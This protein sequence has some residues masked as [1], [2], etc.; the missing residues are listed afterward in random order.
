MEELLEKVFFFG[1]LEY[2]LLSLASCFKAPGLE[3]FK[4]QQELYKKNSSNKLHV[5]KAF[6][7]WKLQ[8]FF[9]ILQQTGN[10]KSKLRIQISLIYFLV[11]FLLDINIKVTVPYN[12]ISSSSPAFAQGGQSLLFAVIINFILNMQQFSKYMD[13]SR[14]KIC[15]LIVILLYIITMVENLEYQLNFSAAFY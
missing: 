8:N 4:N 10:L 14:R 6:K 5:A 15:L 9:T 12:K 7:V 13:T 2:H 11:S 1:V 3:L